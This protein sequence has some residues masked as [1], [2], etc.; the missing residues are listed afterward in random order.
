MI[1]DGFTNLSTALAVNSGLSTR[2]FKG[3]YDFGGGVDVK[4]TRLF[5]LRTEFRDFVRTGETSRIVPLPFGVVQQ[6]SQARQT[7]TVMGGLV[8]RF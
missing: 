4:M 2:N 1:Q 6:V 5:A 8:V 3:V 7:F